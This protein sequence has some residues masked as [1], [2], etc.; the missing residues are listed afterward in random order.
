MTD[1][2]T[3]QYYAQLLYFVDKSQKLGIAGEWMHKAE[4]ESKA[5]PRS[6]VRERTG[7]FSG[8]VLVLRLV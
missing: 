6:I 8:G 3:I 4:T 7:R 1:D 2:K 5:F